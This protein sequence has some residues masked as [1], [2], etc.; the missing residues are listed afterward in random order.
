MG[1][2]PRLSRD[3]GVQLL[4]DSQLESGSIPASTMH[5]VYQ[6]GWLRDGSWCA[7]AL[8]VADRRTQRRPGL[9]QRAGG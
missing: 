5:E 8:D 9:S 6:F 2:M 7:H 4:L 1:P 3:A